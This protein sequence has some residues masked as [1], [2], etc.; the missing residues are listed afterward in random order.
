MV[1][2][3]KELLH[4]HPQFHTGFDQVTEKPGP[5]KCLPIF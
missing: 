5:Q 1:N 2:C 3:T 4:G